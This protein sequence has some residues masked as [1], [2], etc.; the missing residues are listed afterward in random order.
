MAIKIFIGTEPKTNIPLK[1]LAYSIEK[2]AS[3]P[4]Q[5]IKMMG[6]DWTIRPNAFI[7]TGF[8][9]L[10]WDIPRV[11]EYQGFAIYLDVDQL[12]LTD[13]ADLYKSD[14]KY[15]NNKCSVWCTYQ[16]SKWYKKLTPETS[17]MLIDCAKAKDNQPDLEH[18][19]DYIYN[20]P[21]PKK[22]KRYIKIM[23]ELKNKNKLQCFSA[24]YK[25]T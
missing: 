25:R 16:E 12:V 17:V 15:P 5:I 13:I 6:K 10:R 20:D 9:L 21:E 8:S 1:V 18:A 22:R 24:L 3:V 19:L 14:M 2:H 11:C 7:G 4:I 23:R